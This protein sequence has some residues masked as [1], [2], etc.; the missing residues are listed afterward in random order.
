MQAGGNGLFL[1]GDALTAAGTPFTRG[2]EVQIL[3]GRNSET[4][5]SHG[6]VFAI[7][8]AVMK[9]DRPHPKARCAAFPASKLLQTIARGNHYRVECQDGAVKL[10]VNGKVVSGGSEC[11]PRKGYLCLESEGSECHFRNIK[12]RELPS[13]NPKPEEIADVDQGF[14]SLYIWQGFWAGSARPASK[15]TGS[16]P[17]GSWI[18]TARAKPKTRACGAV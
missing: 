15:I 13:T 8:A 3:D 9:P 17:T 2:I 6:D 14:R 4:Y 10:A 7:H 12:I 18:M 5:T 1:W 16:R 11:R